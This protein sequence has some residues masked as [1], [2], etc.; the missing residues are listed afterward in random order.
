MKT[1]YLGGLIVV[2]VVLFV[3]IIFSN[4]GTNVNT[5]S[6]QEFEDLTNQEN[7]F[8]INAHTPY[9]GEIEGTDLIAESWDNMISY[10]NE[11]PKDKSTPIAVYCRSGRMAE[12][13]AKQL[14][15]MGYTNVYNLE[16][17]MKGWQSSGRKLVQNVEETGETK[18]FN[19]IANNWDFIPNEIEVNLGDRVVL[20]VE[21]VEGN[22]GIALFDFG[23]NEFLS[24]GEAVDIEFLA[25]KQGTFSFFC[26]IPC[27]SGHGNMGGQL[28]VN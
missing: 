21:S 24:Q 15:K 20:H 10:E 7:V 19:M 28:I 3:F 14:L 5:I 6:V 9:V 4:S 27:G 11:L 2:L 26:N 12:T 22:H 18:E 1:K 23:V 17:G 16:G 13:S 25:D 8:V